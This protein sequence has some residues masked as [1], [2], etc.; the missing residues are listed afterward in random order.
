M[1]HCVKLSRAQSTMKQLQGF[2]IVNTY[3][4]LQQFTDKFW[5]PD[6]VA[7]NNDPEDDFHSD[8]FTPVVIGRNLD[9]QR[10]IVHTPCGF[11]SIFSV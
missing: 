3:G 1:Q 5:F 10:V 2:D 8:W 7:R 9:A 6:L 4:S 11:F